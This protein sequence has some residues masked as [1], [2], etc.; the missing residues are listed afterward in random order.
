MCLVDFDFTIETIAL[1]KKMVYWTAQ[2][3]QL[4]LETGSLEE[5]CKG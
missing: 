5:F 1:K 4:S 2:G 3:M